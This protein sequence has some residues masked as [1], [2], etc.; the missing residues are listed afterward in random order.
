M[1]TI[2]TPVRAKVPQPYREL[3]QRYL[4]L[5]NTARRAAGLKNVTAAEVAG[6]MICFLLDHHQQSII[7]G[8]E[9]LRTDTFLKKYEDYLGPG[10]APGAAQVPD[11]RGAPGD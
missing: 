5:I 7:D 4:V 6:A 11:V 2:L 1:R 3:L 9:A 8:Y 10:T